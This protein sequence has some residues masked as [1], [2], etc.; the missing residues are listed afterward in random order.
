MDMASLGMSIRPILEA[1]SSHQISFHFVIWDD[2]QYVDGA[3]I[4]QVIRRNCLHGHD[5]LR[6]KKRTK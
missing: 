6:S 2:L 1:V 5:V 3:S 4:E